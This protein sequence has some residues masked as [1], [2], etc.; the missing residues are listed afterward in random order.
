MTTPTLDDLQ[1]G[2]LVY[3]PAG[4]SPQRARPLAM[5]LRDAG[6][7]DYPPGDI[8]LAGQ[9]LRADGSNPPQYRTTAIN[10]T[11]A[12]ITIASPGIRRCVATG[13]PN[14]YDTIA[15]YE[16][17]ELEPGWS[18]L[19]R[20]HLSGANLCPQHALTVI[21]DGTTFLHAPDA[22]DRETG[23]I[24]CTCGT[25]IRPATASKTI[26]VVQAACVLA[27]GAHIATM[28]PRRL[29]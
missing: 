24:T 17:G 29:S 9:I 23:N 3:I 27:Y 14:S 13:C 2:R 10:A 25:L 20:G 21:P 22:M 6:P 16:T 7:S 11:L 26:H 19:Q 8:W 1:P 18:M 5:C 15:T 12:K 28:T 4:A